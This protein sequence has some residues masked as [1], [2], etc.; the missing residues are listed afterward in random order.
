MSLQIKKEACLT[1]ASKYIAINYPFVGEKV[2]H[3]KVTR[4]YVPSEKN[5]G[6]V[7]AKRIGGQPHALLAGLLE[8]CDCD[9]VQELLR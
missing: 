6:D 7:L 1:E 5:D 3:G 4:C 8:I 9:A 2:E